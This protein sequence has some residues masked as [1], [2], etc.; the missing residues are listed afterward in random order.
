MRGATK[1]TC[2]ALV[3]SSILTTGSRADANIFSDAVGWVKGLFSSPPPAVQRTARLRFLYSTEDARATELKGTFPVAGLRVGVFTKRSLFGSP[4]IQSA[5][6][7]DAQGRVTLPYSIQADQLV[8]LRI[9]TDSTKLKTFPGK[10]NLFLSPHQ[11]DIQ[12][13]AD[14][15]S[16]EIAR[17]LWWGQQNPAFNLV[18]GVHDSARRARVLGERLFNGAVADVVKKVTVSYPAW[19]APN[20]TS[21]TPLPDRVVIVDTDWHRSHTTV[22]HEVGHT[23]WFAARGGFWNEALGWLLLGDFHS[24]HSLT[25]EAANAEL[26]L[27]EGFADWYSILA[28][29]D[30]ARANNRKDLANHQVSWFG[31]THQ[32]K[33]H[34]ELAFASWGERNETNVACALYDLADTDEDALG[35]VP[36]FTDRSHFGTADDGARQILASVARWTS[37]TSRKPTLTELFRQDLAPV[38]SRAGEDALRM[39]G[40]K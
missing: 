17:D 33:D 40:V 21:Y 25:D 30:F 26:A 7:T 36:G 20:G 19:I 11:L 5:A 15:S 35:L 27:S 24:K 4:E 12:F 32:G 34:P 2:V 14:E 39:N 23:F 28:K 10:W 8:H 38:F 31:E 29:D 6:E 16:R 13:S 3:A 1:A 18:L 37:R 22:F 9:E